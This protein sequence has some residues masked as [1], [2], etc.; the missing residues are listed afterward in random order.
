MATLVTGGAGFIGSHLCNRLV[1]QGEEV[2]C[3]DNFMTGRRSNVQALLGHPLFTLMESDVAEALP[4]LP[5]IERIYHLASPASPPIY[6]RHPIAT[7]RVNAEGTRRL[8]DLATQ[9]RARFLYASTSEVYGDPLVHPQPE[10]Y[11]GNVSTTGPRSMYDE[12][13]RYGEALAFAYLAEHG[14]AIR[15]V[16]I[17]NT[18][19][20]C[21]D[22]DDGRVVS[23]FVMQ[24]LRGEPLTIYGD[25]L[26]TRSFQ[27]VD[28][29][30]D[31]LVRA[32]ESGYAGPVN[33]GNPE[34][35]TMLQLAR[36][37][38]ELVGV[39]TGITYLPLPGDD[40]RQRRP[41][42]SVAWRELGWRPTV[43]VAVGVSRTIEHFRQ[44]LLAGHR[45]LE[46]SFANGVLA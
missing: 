19:G 7:M 15:V 29:L 26:Q 4:A 27:Y 20:P 34:E 40:P 37:V 33:L 6:Q 28:D 12:A 14:V 10:H 42:I 30:V 3:V 25:G 45:T 8:L 18:Y 1:H 24:A 2:I 13:K 11:R 5:G 16:R 36:L 21:L 39:N 9:N 46:H 41:D 43:P 31:G 35:Y 17:F 38:H 32:M 44:E 22:P 23:N